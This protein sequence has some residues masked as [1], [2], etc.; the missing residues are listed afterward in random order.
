MPLRKR[1]LIDVDE[2]LADFQTPTFAVI[3][4]LFGRVLTPHDFEVWDIFGLFSEEEKQAIFEELEK[5]GFCQ[6]LQ[7]TPGSIEAVRELRK[8]VD[9]YPV[10]SPFHSPTW[11]HERNT[12]LHE[13]HGFKKREIVHTG[14]KFLVTG[15]ALLDDN[16]SHVTTW[17]EE[18][19]FGLGMLW[20]IPNTRTL[21]LDDL[22]V[23]T[24]DEVLQRAE[25]LARRKTVYDLL[26]DAEWSRDGDPYPEGNYCRECG[27]SAQGSQIPT[28]KPDCALHIILSWYRQRS[29]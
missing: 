14:S 27:A 13:Y 3:E 28:H 2:V 11:V 19:P 21:G 8:I 12:W 24:W 20:H 9:V 6:G 23:H 22:R 25:S 26:E 10:T 18:H 17:A 29:G 16:P 7:P 5:P 15:D 1:L 4:K